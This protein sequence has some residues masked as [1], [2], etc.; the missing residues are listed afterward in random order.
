M[1][2]KF[3]KFGMGL[4]VMLIIAVVGFSL[5]QAYTG[6]AEINQVFGFGLLGLSALGLVR[7][8]IASGEKTLTMEDFISA[9][10]LTGTPIVALF[11]L[12]KVGINL[13]SIAPLVGASG[14]FD[15]NFAL[16]GALF[17]LIKNN[18]LITGLII[19]GVYWFYLRKKLGR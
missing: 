11:M 15:V 19:A 2:D 16:Q 5:Y 9:A 18:L 12:P 3:E 17:E 6:K 8:F 13:F 7:F 1:S 10:I 14:N 4:V